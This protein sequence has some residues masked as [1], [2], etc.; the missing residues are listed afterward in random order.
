MKFS[1]FRMIVC[2]ILC[3][4][5]IFGTFRPKAEAVLLESGLAIGIAACLILATA[6]VIFNPETVEDIKAIG[7]SF[8]TYMYQWGTEAEKL[9]EVEDWF[10]GLSIYDG[11]AEDDGSWESPNDTKI[12]LAKG[13]LAGITAWVAAVIMGTWK[14]EKEVETA[15]EGFSYYGGILLPD[16]ENVWT[17]K[18]KYPCAFI[19]KYDSTSYFLYLGE[20]YYF[21]VN[22]V[23]KDW[24]LFINSGVRYTS[25]SSGW[26]LRYDF[27][28]FDSTSVG[29]LLVWSTFDIFNQDGSIYLAGSE[30]VYVQTE[31]VEPSTYVG[32]VPSDLQEGNITEEEIPLVDIDYSQV[33]PQG[34]TALES[35]QSLAGQLASGAI[36]YED[37]LA[38]VT[39]EQP[40]FTTNIPYGSEVTYSQ[41]EVA[42]PITVEAIVSDGGTISYEWYR[43]G[44]D[45][46][47]NV[48]APEVLSTSNSFIPPTD[49]V[50]T[51][52]YYCRAMNTDPNGMVAWN[53]SPSIA[54]HVVAGAGSD[55]DTDV[56]DKVGDAV[57]DALD[58]ASAKEEEKINNTGN[59]VSQQLLDAVP[60]YSTA[61]LPAVKNLSDALGYTGTSCVLTMPAITVPAV[62][63]LFSETK[64][65]DEQQINFEEYFNKMPETVLTLIRALFDITVVFFCLREI[66]DTI[67]Q[68]LT[69]F[70][71]KDVKG[72]ED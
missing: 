58:D 53:Y 30:A 11:S 20:S 17:D 51:A 24:S 39:A 34:Q 66:N 62:S 8:Q 1:V 71:V 27:S 69:G 55:T 65:L 61:F 43:Y 47:G 49:E 4:S 18:E 60:D 42:E 45:P 23:S 16:I 21:D 35:I 40:V 7:N 37:Y 48:Y 38:A 57:S 67:S 44:T 14:V 19:R 6:G 46:N 28:T 59:D 64:I 56:A 50:C 52:Y 12:K 10:G 54:V 68:A 15:T 25:T 26:S 70:K 36:T 63:N 41:G 31:I 9:D 22:S 32:D 33:L 13:I 2:L 72:G 3:V 29:E 5:L